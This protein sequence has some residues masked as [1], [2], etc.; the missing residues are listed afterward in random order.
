[1]LLAKVGT[2]QGKDA[3]GPE[4]LKLRQMGANFK[5]Q[6]VVEDGKLITGRDDKVA[7]LFAQRVL[8]RLLE[9]AR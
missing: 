7:G 5:D 1:L 4:P 3:T 9:K 2:L 6:P 8:E